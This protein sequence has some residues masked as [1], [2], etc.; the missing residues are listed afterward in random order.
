MVLNSPFGNLTNLG[1]KHIELLTTFQQRRGRMSRENK[2]GPSSK[3]LGPFLD[4]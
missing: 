3:P 1:P 4:R 2:R